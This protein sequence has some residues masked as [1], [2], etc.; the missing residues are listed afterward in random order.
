[1]DE[2]ILSMEVRFQ[3]EYLLVILRQLDLLEL[4]L[5]IHLND[6]RLLCLFDLLKLFYLKT[7][8]LDVRNIFLK[9]YFQAILDLGHLLHLVVRFL[10][11]VLQLNIAGL[12]PLQLCLC[13]ILLLQH[14]YED[15]P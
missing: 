2:L 4:N 15:C 8:T 3:L 12:E 10:N 13:V 1:M 11:L 5:I 6:L 14:F 9:L 7:E